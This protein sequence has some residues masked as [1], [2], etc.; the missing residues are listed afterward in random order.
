MGNFLEVSD[1][2]AVVGQ[3]VEGIIGGKKVK[4]VWGIRVFVDDKYVGR[5]VVSDKPKTSSYGLLKN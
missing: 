5:I 2:K 1:F 3:G 4:I